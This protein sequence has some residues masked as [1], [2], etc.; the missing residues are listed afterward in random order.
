[1]IVEPHPLDYDWQF[2]DSSIDK[3]SS[4]VGDEFCITCGVPSLA[5]QLKVMG[6]EVVNID[7]NP[8]RLPERQ[9]DISREEPINISSSLVVIDPPWYP[10]EF[11][12]WLTWAAQHVPSNGR[13]LASIWPNETRPTAMSERNELFEK[14]K[15]WADIN[16]LERFFKY[17]VPIF[18]QESRRLA[19][20][21]DAGFPWRF[22]D[23]VEL[24]VRSKPLL[25]EPIG[26]SSIWRRFVWDGY[27]LALRERGAPD[28]ATVVRKLGAAESWSFPSVSRREPQRYLIDL[29]SSWNEVAIVEGAKNL[30]KDLVKFTHNRGSTDFHY[31]TLGPI[32][33]SWKIPNRPFGR[34]F[35]WVHCD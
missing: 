11:Y 29:W 30:E 32:L 8:L 19:G 12:R 3:L 18:E 24:K 34:V 23:L 21:D 2:S 33:E 31:E 35:T 17:K 26:F 7:R 28:S 1:M 27:Q 25:A 13:I 16:V 6:K 5:F 10:E 15:A 22:G 20:V 4:I 14:I 9:I